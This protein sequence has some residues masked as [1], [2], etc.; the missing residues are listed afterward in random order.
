MTVWLVIR[1][2][3]V[4]GITVESVA[5]VFSA[6]DKA[7]AWVCRM[8][9]DRDVSYYTEDHEVDELAAQCTTGG[10]DGST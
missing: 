2:R 7:V 1:M 5:A 8:P 9:V 4:E 6:E 10:S 3:E